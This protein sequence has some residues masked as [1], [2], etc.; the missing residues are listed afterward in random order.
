[1]QKIEKLVIFSY[2]SNFLSWWK[3]SAQI[4]EGGNQLQDQN[5]RTNLDLENSENETGNS[6]KPRGTPISRICATMSQ[7]SGWKKRGNKFFQRKTT[8]IPDP[9][10][11]SKNRPLIPLRTHFYDVTPA[12]KSSIDCHCQDKIHASNS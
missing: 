3:K 12:T 2:Y 8:V 9:P 6:R 4:I 7:R 10:D 1:L 5:R 11:E